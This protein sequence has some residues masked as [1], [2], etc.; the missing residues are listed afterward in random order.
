MSEAARRAYPIIIVGRLSIEYNDGKI[1]G[2]GDCAIPE[3]S[4][5]DVLNL[6]AELQGRYPYR[7]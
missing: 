1:C 5:Q 6:I 3:N 7:T 4:L 2:A